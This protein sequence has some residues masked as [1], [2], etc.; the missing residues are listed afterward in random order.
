MIIVSELRSKNKC[1][2]ALK[3]LGSFMILQTAAYAVVG[4]TQSVEQ[5]EHAR[6]RALVDD[7]AMLTDRIKSNMV[8]FSFSSL[9]RT[10]CF[11]Q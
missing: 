4:L 11:L 1:C 10:Q 8:K 6:N 7:G 5:E 9:F 2:V 3:L